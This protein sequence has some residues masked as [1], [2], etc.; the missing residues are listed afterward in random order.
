MLIK[1]IEDW[2]KALDNNEAVGVILMDLSKAFDYLPHDLL[3][4]KLQGYGMSEMACCLLS[5]YLKGRKQRVKYGGTTSEW[6]EILK[7]VPQGSILGPLL[8]NIFMNDFFY[9]MEDTCDIYNYADDNT[10]SFHDKDIQYVI[11]TLEHAANIAIGWFQANGMKVNADKFQTMLLGSHKSTDLTFV[12]DGVTLETD[13][14]VKLLGVYID[15]KLNFHDH[16]S[17]ICSQAAKQISV[18]RRFTK[19]LNEKERLQI[20]N[21][22]ILANFNYCPLAWH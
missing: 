11:S 1:I 13:R 12:I 18:L 4:K 21:A 5:S 9:H 10:L 20:F 6:T 3:I 17:H 8:F 14:C 7:G 2:K 19:V 22:F 15:D 16:V